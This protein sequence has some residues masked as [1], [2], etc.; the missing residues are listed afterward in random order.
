MEQSYA[1]HSAGKCKVAENKTKTLKVIQ[2]SCIYT[3]L[4][5]NSSCLKA[6]E[7]NFQNPQTD[8]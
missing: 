3:A 5:H 8:E 2:I 4:I 1:G 7:V 6:C